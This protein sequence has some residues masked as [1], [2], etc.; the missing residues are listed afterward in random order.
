MKITTKTIEENL[1]DFHELE[2]LYRINKKDFKKSID[3]LHKNSKNAAVKIWFERLNYKSERNFQ[4][5][6]NEIL[7]II[8]LG[9][10]SGLIS[11][12]PDIFKLEWYTF[13]PEGFKINDVTEETFYSRNISFIIFPALCFYYFLK[14]KFSIKYLVIY[15]LILIISSL[16][17]NSFPK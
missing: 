1:N 8:L 17:I 7:L 2:K 16:F 11:K 4:I 12:I 9:L 5:K 14:D 15:A 6:K 3:Y 10:F 13:N